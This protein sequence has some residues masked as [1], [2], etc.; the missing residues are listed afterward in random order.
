MIRFWSILVIVIGMFE[1]AAYAET[2]RASRTVMVFTGSRQAALQ[3]QPVRSAYRGG[4]QRRVAY[5]TNELSGGGPPPPVRT[6]FRR[7]FTGLGV[8]LATG[9]N[10]GFAKAE[11]VKDGATRNAMAISVMFEKK[12]NDTFFLCPE[13]G[14]VERGVQTQ[15]AN[16]MGVAVPGSVRLNYLEVSLLMKA[17]LML[18]GPRWK[19]FFVAGP[20]GALALSR[21]VEVLGLVDLSLAERF[22]PTDVNMVMGGG[23]E[24]TVNPEFSVMTHLRHHMGL[25]DIDTTSDAFYT[26]GIQLLVG[27]QYRL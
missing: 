20:S 9:L 22:K 26:R 14:Y 1:T 25:V 11:P 12:L 15:L 27:V 24:Y 3:R 7:H 4:R 2:S 21:G 23:V 17:K 16:V 18:A 10:A 19:V 13:L 8:Q 5:V 6:G